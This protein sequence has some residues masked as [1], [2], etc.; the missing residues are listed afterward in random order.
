M[1]RKNKGTKDIDKID[2]LS[3][4]MDNIRIAEYIEMLSNPKKLILMNF[5]MGL[6]R[7][8]GM[9]LGFTV[10]TALF[11]GALVYLMRGWVNLPYIG[12][13]IAELLEVIETYR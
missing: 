2:V 6:I 12:K 7:G 10:L 3:R 13:I 1:S 4:K 5:V 8:I 9:G 11:V